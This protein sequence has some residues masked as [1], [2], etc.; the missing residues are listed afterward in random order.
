MDIL[1][2][3]KLNDNEKN[4][5]QTLL[6]ES[7]ITDVSFMQNKLFITLL[8]S[9]MIILKNS[10]LDVFHLLKKYQNED[11]LKKYESNVNR[12]RIKRKGCI[13]EWTEENIEYLKKYYYSKSLDEVSKHIEKSFYQISL[14]VIELELVN[15]KSWTEDDLEFLQKN[16]MMSNHELGKILKRTMYS[17]KS[18][19]KVLKK[20]N[21]N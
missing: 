9:K 8:N 10:D 14:K 16:I 15:N 4:Y 7:S 5:F 17:I 20:I 18:K 2:N 11:Y 6:S 21:G 13:S 19:K 12:K 1:E 3:I